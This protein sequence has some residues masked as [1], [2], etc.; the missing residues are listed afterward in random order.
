MPSQAIFDIVPSNISYI[1]VVK[2]MEGGGGGGILC[3]ILFELDN[4]F[5]YKRVT[6][7]AEAHGTGMTIL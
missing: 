4:Y 5:H 2:G 6:P 1:K 3:F 7:I